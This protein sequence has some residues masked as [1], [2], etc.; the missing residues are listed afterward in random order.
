MKDRLNAMVLG[1]LV[2][3]ALSLGSHWVY[4]TNVI[5][6]KFG[7]V[8]GY[9]DP[10]TSFHKGKKAGEQTHYGDQV[11]VLMASLEAVSGFDLEDFA[12]RWRLFFETYTG[13]FDHATKDTLQHLS[14]G[15][16]IHTCGSES[17]DLA[18]A[19]RIAP[20][21]HVYA[22]DVEKLVAA[23]RQQTAFT[24][25]NA[26]VIETADFFSRT[27][28]KVLGGAAP[29]QAVD[30]V[31]G[32]RFKGSTIASLVKDGLDSAERETRQ[33]IADFGQECS[34]EAALPGAIHLIARYENDF[35]AALVEN[36][37]AGGD[38]S[39]RGMPAAMILGAHHGMEAIPGQ[40]LDGLASRARVEEF[41]SSI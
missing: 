27:V 2:A 41:F 37:M 29:L 15:K 5:D 23:V 9:H 25:D 26:T 20:L 35:E 17:D 3:D 39:A 33:V 34:I 21:C 40:W 1:S 28:A 30:E 6:R 7:R 22:G 10:L 36:V 11:L 31:V 8:D 12:Q 13:Y 16:D 32:D 14:D 18:G 19:S 4:N 24:H 38:S